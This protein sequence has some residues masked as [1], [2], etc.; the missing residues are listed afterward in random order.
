MFAARG[1]NTQR[2]ARPGPFSA[3][4]V[5]ATFRDLYAFILGS[6]AT[7]LLMTIIGAQMEEPVCYASPPHNPMWDWQDWWDWSEHR[8]YQIRMRHNYYPSIPE[9]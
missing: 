2:R 6:L 9:Y 4:C 7:V 1:S 8:E 5:Q 3:M